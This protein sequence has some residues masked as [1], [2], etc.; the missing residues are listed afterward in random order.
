MVIAVLTKRLRYAHLG[1]L[2]ELLVDA[3]ICVVL[4]FI[5][6]PLLQVSLSRNDK[7]FLQEIQSLLSIMSQL[8]RLCGEK[9][10]LALVDKSL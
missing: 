3:E 7:T 9:D 1:H 6:N 4:F 8:T 5:D 2:G 10:N